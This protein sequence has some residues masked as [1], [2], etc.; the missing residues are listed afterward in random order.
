MNLD[1]YSTES[2]LNYLKKDRDIAFEFKQISSSTNIKLKPYFDE[3]YEDDMP[4]E[5]WKGH[6][7]FKNDG[8]LVLCTPDGKRIFKGSFLNIGSDGIIEAI[9]Y[10]RNDTSIKVDEDG[11]VIIQ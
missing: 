4:I 7:G 3:V 8:T 2:I 5:N 1:N 9:K 6:F 11:K 10:F